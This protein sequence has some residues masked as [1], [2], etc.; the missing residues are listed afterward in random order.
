MLQYAVCLDVCRHSVL[1]DATGVKGLCEVAHMFSFNL[2]CKKPV[3]ILESV[4][5]LS[6]Q[7]FQRLT[8][9]AM[10]HDRKTFMLASGAVDLTFSIDRTLVCA[11]AFRRITLPSSTAFS[12][13]S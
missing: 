10:V 4:P 6:A 7:Q 11:G 12:L 1:I 5:P 9:R 2:R 13:F 8:S 3:V